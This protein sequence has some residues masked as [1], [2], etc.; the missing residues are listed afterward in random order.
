MRLG[1]RFAPTPNPST[2]LK[3]LGDPAVSVA[4]RGGAVSARSRR[5]QSK[6]SETKKKLTHILCM[7]IGK[8]VRRNLLHD[9][10]LGF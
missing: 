5:K 10:V 8:P 1:K 2:L 3:R 6:P 4:G 9:R 7:N